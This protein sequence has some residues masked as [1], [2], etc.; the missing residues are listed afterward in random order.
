MGSTSTSG[1]SVLISRALGHAP[2]CG[3]A[4]ARRRGAHGERLG[5]SDMEG[6]AFER[7]RK[8]RTLEGEIIANHSRTDPL[9]SPC[10]AEGG[11]FRSVK[12]ERGAP[13]LHARRGAHTSAPL[14]GGLTVGQHLL[15]KGNGLGLGLPRD[16]PLAPAA[17][18]SQ[19][20]G[21]LWASFPL[22]PC[23]SAVRAKTKLSVGG[24]FFLTEFSKNFPISQI[25]DE[26]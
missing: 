25:H 10:P 9:G 26:I 14:D 21:G 5:R 23:T 12:W 1:G 7:R 24:A 6:V 15:H 8:Q 19:G 4:E 3:E 22:G 18:A 2:S 17:A 11:I 20:G 16:H 13:P